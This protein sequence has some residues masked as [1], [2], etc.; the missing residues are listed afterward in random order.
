MEI[1]ILEFNPFAENTYILYDE[2][3]ECI[4][5]DPGCNNETEEKALSDFIS[6]KK[7]TPKKLIN[8]HFHIDHVLGNQYVADKYKLTLEMHE[9]GMFFFEK[10]D[11]IAKTY[12]IHYKGSPNPGNFLKEG[13][14]IEFGNTKLNIIHV[15]GHSK[16]SICLH[17][18]ESQN[19]IV[20][21]VLF[22][23]SIGRTDL[24]GG[25]HEVLL[26]GIRNKL[27]VLPAETRVYPGHGPST[28]IGYE[29]DH[30]PFF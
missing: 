1:A 15:P 8:T 23:D 12:G 21:D 18:P 2:T 9:Q 7:L 25:E 11:Q 20:G 29:K 16:G 26:S 28:T 30:N 4:I 24:P 6:S 3:G 5:V 19:L 13:D 17:E 22:R 14:V 10:Q 27:F